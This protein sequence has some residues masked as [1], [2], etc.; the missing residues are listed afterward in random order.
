MSDP[1]AIESV[2]IDGPL[3]ITAVGGP[4]PCGA[5]TQA[6][7]LS[8]GAPRWRGADIGP[9]WLSGGQLIGVDW[10]RR[11][12]ARVWHLDAA[13][14]QG[15]TLVASLPESPIGPLVAGGLVLVPAGGAGDG[16][17]AYGPV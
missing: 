3:L 15:D 14:G 9:V 4:N 7:D 6:W 1:C 16:L 12:G 5:G 11:G 17:V 8:T 10:I 2:V 13:T